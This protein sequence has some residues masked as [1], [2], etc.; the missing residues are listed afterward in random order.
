MKNG[1]D[2]TIVEHLGDCLAKLNRQ[3]EAVDAWKRALAN[4]EAKH[5]PSEKVLKS[6][7]Q[8]LGIKATAESKTPAG[9]TAPATPEGK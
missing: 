7:R 4:E 1:D 5:P 8:K 9:N 2:S 6:L 3:P